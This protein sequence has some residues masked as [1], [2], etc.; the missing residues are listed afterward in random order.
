MSTQITT[1]YYQQVSAN[2]T[3]LSQQMGSILRGGVE[4]E[5]VPGEKP[6]F[7]QVGSAAAV[8]FA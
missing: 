8:N 6:F 1:E 4:E 3:L 5:S 2:V 7:E